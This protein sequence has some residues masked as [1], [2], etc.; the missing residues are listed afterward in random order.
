MV[1]KKPIPV[2][3]VRLHPRS[4]CQPPLCRHLNLWL[5]VDVVLGLFLYRFPF[6]RSHHFRGRLHSLVGVLCG[7]KT[8]LSALSFRRMSIVSGMLGGFGERGSVM[9]MN[10]IVDAR[11]FDLGDR[12]KLVVVCMLVLKP[13]VRLYWIDRDLVF[14]LVR[15]GRL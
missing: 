7:M 6:Y 11:I 14:L 5:H 15:D 2:Q 4:L 13:R 12:A 1:F 3:V 9:C 8:I 10:V